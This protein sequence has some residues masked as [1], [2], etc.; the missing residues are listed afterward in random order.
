MLNVVGICIKFRIENSM[1]MNVSVLMCYN[2]KKTMYALPLYSDISFS[3][4]RDIHLKMI[5]T[6]VLMLLFTEFYTD[7]SDL[8][9]L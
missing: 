9:Y 8:K 2:V 3:Y 1:E 5:K 4:F 7:D 6:F